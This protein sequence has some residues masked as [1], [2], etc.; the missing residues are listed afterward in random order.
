MERWSW[1]ARS[2]QL[3]QAIADAMF[4]YQSTIVLIIGKPIIYLVIAVFRRV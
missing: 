4:M 2:V 1:I 3:M